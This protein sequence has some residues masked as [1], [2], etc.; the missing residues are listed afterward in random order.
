MER[1][2][3]VYRIHIAII[4]YVTMEITKKDLQEF[5]I[6]VVLIGHLWKIGTRSMAR[7][8]M[9]MAHPED[10]ILFGLQHE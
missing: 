10:V 7:I 1:I 8:W 4:Q 3:K 9:G 6:K 5:K 2:R